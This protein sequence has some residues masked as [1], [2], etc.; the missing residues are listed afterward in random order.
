MKKHVQYSEYLMNLRTKGRGISA[1]SPYIV[2]LV[3][4]EINMILTKMYRQK[5]MTLGFYPA[6]TTE[7]VEKLNSAISF[8]KLEIS[9]NFE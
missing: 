1:K 3:C 8:I 6:V 4:R 9:E 7:G 5:N 2:L